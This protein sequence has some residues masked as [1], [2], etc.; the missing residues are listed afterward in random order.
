M[1]L[2]F[3]KSSLKRHFKLIQCKGFLLFIQPVLV[4]STNIS[5]E[6]YITND[7]IMIQPKLPAKKT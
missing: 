7:K 4:F 6:A 1:K 3:L 2:V 5:L